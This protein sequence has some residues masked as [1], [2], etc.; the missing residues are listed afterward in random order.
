MAA[1]LQPLPSSSS[2]RLDVDPRDPRCMDRLK[3]FLGRQKEEEKEE[4]RMFSRLPLEDGS[5]GGLGESSAAAASTT[6][7]T[8]EKEV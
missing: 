3:A 8:T 2:P 6:T 4:E 1:L 7:K 5:N